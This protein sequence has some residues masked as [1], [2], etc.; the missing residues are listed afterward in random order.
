MGLIEDA[1]ERISR[2][3]GYRAEVTGV[4]IE[5]HERAVFESHSPA[6][7]VLV[8]VDTS[9]AK[10]RRERSVLG[11]AA[12]AGLPVP[13]I[14][15]GEE[16]APS[17]LVLERIEGSALDDTV[18]RAAWADAGRCLRV[19]HGVPWPARAGPAN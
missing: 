11:A 19:L 13:V 17:L 14:V 10:Y 7:A 5:H 15:L 1:V 4:L 8:K 16:G 6:G 2:A 18:D 9:R 3:W 12:D